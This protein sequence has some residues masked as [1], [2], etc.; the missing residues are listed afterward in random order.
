MR[1]WTLHPKYLDTK[2]LVAVWREALLA[3]KVLQEK[4]KGYKHHP[5]LIRFKEQKNPVVAIGTYLWHLYQEAQQRG[6]SF[7]ASKISA[8]GKT[9]RIR[10]TQGQLL[11]EWEHLQK[12]LKSRDLRK[13]KAA[14][15]IPYPD[16]H[17]L[18]VIRDGDV[19]DWEIR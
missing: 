18:F 1:L 16:A 17:P 7:D 9:P 13:Y 10:C 4:T 8:Q 11:Y 15:I 2:G 6:Y 3:Q 19:E 12:K 5:Q 14:K